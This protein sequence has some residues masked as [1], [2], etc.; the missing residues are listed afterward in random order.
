M[1]DI[2]L[3]NYLPCILQRYDTVWNPAT[4]RMERCVIEYLLPHRGRRIA[5]SPAA[6]AAA[7]R[8]GYPLGYYKA[9]GGFA[10]GVLRLDGRYGKK[11]TRRRV[12]YR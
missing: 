12:G 10:E 5:T 4:G 6:I 1:S 8:A 7:R 3:N 9:S 2:N 11:Q